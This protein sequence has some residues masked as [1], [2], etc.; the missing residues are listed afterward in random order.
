[1]PNTPTRSGVP[2]V[3][4]RRP[5][6]TVKPAQKSGAAWANAKPS[7]RRTQPRASAIIHSAWPPPWWSQVTGRMH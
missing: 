5:L 6:M 7:G 3:A 4:R 2:R 1:M